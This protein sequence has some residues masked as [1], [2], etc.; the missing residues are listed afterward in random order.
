MYLHEPPEYQCPLCAIIAGREHGQNDRVARQFRNR[1][2]SLGHTTHGTGSLLLC[3]LQHFENIYALPQEV[4]APSVWGQS[5]LGRL[6]QAGA[7]LRGSLHQAAQRA[8]WHPGSLCYHQHIVPRYTGDNFYT[9]RP[10]PYAFEH[11]IEFASRI[12]AVLGKVRL[13]PS[14][15]GDGHRQNRLARAPASV[16]IRRAGQAFPASAL[17]SNVRPRK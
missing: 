9:E 3:S 2:L 7:S 4:G 1:V 15:R 6:S 8:G 11:R 16:I 13:T 12:K 5:A 17:S 14:L 10:V